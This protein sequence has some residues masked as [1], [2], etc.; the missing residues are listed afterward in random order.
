MS[1]RLVL[2][3][4]AICALA[5]LSCVDFTP[6]VDARSDGTGSVI[7]L[8][9]GNSWTPAVTTSARPPSARGSIEVDGAGTFRF[10]PAEVQTVRP[11]IFVAGH[12]SLLD[13]LVLAGER[14][15]IDLRYHYDEDMATHVIDSIDGTTGWWYEAHY[16]DGWFEPNAF[17]MDLYPYKDGTTIHVYGEDPDRISGILDTFAAEVD[18]QG[19]NH[20]E[21]VLPF[22]G[23]EDP[24]GKR[25]F[26]DVAVTSHNVRSDVLQPDTITALDIL[27]S[28]GEQGQL[29]SVGL[30]W[31]SFIGAADPIDNYF[32]ERIDGAQ[33]QLGCGYV[34]EVGPLAF[35][36]F[37][38]SHIHIPA[39]VRV[40]VS[41]EY[42][43]WFWICL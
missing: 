4:L 25:T 1:R 42:A 18:R 32:V 43:K 10:D 34:Y 20:G 33:A 2:L 28:L 8:P 30:T 21:V 9:E 6:P 26:H 37:T 40:L 13:V 23:I 35:E 22:V 15:F 39:D 14:E 41:P 17:R 29:S 12:F 5:S 31:Y 11:D 27:L 3:S 19:R 16:A 36:G 7:V 38:G 24:T